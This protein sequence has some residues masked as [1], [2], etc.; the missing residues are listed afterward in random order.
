MLIVM[1]IVAVLGTVT[2]II[3]QPVEYLKESRDSA[4]FSDINNL[5]KD[6]QMAQLDNL[7]MGTSSVIYVSVPDTSPT[8][9]NLGLAPVN[10]YVYSC[11]TAINLRKID[12]NGWLPINFTL[13]QSINHPLSSLPIDPVNS[14]S[15]NLYYIYVKNE[16]NYSIQT[17][18]LES[19]KYLN[20]NPNGFSLGSG[21]AVSGG[22]GVSAPGVPDYL[23]ALSSSTNNITRT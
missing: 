21:G 17:I 9:A 14:T 12:G 6:L 15:S 18:S 3:I 16:N 7:S 23:V 2:I 5:N 1:G 8:C 20:K 10:G 13:F 19:Q 4:R 11:S 22:S